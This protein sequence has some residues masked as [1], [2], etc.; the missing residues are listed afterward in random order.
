M[1]KGALVRLCPAQGGQGAP[2][3]RRGLPS[4]ASSLPQS[5]DDDDLQIHLLAGIHGQAL[6][7]EGHTGLWGW[8]LGEPWG[9]VPAASPGCG[10]ALT[11]PCQHLCPRHGGDRKPPRAKPV[12]C[13]RPLP[14]SR[15][16]PGLAGSSPFK[17]AGSHFPASPTPSPAQ[18]LPLGLARTPGVLQK[19]KFIKEDPS[20]KEFLGPGSI[21]AQE[22]PEISPYDVSPLCPSVPTC[23]EPGQDP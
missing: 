3:T 15:S 10:C 22:H 7:R 13:P 2:S 5:S 8:H 11:V 17:A 23:S 19:I 21:P 1:R 18:S 14:R 12:P 4:L 9:P 16:T 6:G 20:Q